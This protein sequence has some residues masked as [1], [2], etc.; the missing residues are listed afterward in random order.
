M[1]SEIQVAGTIDRSRRSFMTGA[2]GLGAAALAA[3]GHNSFG[4][5]AEAVKSQAS[6]DPASVAAPQMAFPGSQ[7]EFSAAFKSI[8]VHENAHVDFLKNALGTHARPKP[9]FKNLLQANVQ[10]F[11]TLATAFENVGAGAYLNAAYYINS[12]TYLSA[13]ASIALVEGRHAGFLNV[14]TG[15][16][17]TINN[18]NFEREDSPGFV[19]QQVAPFIQDLNGGPPVSYGLYSTPANDL[20]ILNFALALEYLE[21]EFYN[22]NVPMFY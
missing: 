15:Q 22:I 1:E 17:I 20:V 3:L 14:A 7:A 12:K 11:I 2:A 13:S 16:P 8:V 21:A 9:N 5:A 6:F 4:R 10:D 19:A 18:A